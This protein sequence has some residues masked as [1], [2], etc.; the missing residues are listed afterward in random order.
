MDGIA[1]TNAEVM[2]M[3]KYGG[4]TSSYW[5]DVRPRLSP[6]T[7][8]GLSE[9]SVNFMRLFNTAI[10]VSKQGESRRGVHAVY[11]RID[12]GD[13]EEF[14]DIRGD[15][16]E[17]QHLFPGVL[18]P[19]EWMVEMIAGDK[20]KRKIWA[21]VL[22]SRAKTGTPYIVFTDNMN[23]NTVDVYKDKG[24]LIK[25]SNVCTEIALPSNEDE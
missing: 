2:M 1:S 13:I 18:V 6:I 5:G 16:N 23:D 14:L 3:S 9:G 21:K 10:D 12:H 11:Q 22:E 20:A 17:I 24:L 25:A 19:S 7:N 15:G 8:N 4:G